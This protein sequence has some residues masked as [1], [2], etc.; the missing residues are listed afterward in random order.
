ML[1]PNEERRRSGSHYTPR[2]LTEP[3]VRTMLWRPSSNGYR[4][5][6]GRAPTPARADPR[7]SRSATRPWAPAAFLVETCRQLGDALVEAWHAHDALPTIPPDENEVIFARR[8]VAQRCLYGV[9]KNSMAVDL[10]KVSLWLVTLA[11]D[12]PLTFLAHALRHG[13]SLVGL[14]RGQI[15]AFHWNPGKPR[16]GEGFETMRVR[17]RTA[18]IARLRQLIR[19]ADDT[20]PDSELRQLWEQAQP[21]LDNVRLLGDLALA[22]F[23]T[24]SRPREREELRNQFADEVVNGTADHHRGR[25]EEWRSTERPLV[26]FHWQ[27]EFPEVFDRANPGFDAIIGNPPFAGKNTVAAGNTRGYPDW[28]KETHEGSHGNADLVAHFF[29]RAFS[30][31]RGGGTFGLIATNTIAQGDTRAT[32][33]RWSAPTAARS[34]RPTHAR[35]GPDKQRSSSAS[36]T[37]SK[38][39]TRAPKTRRYG[40]RDDHG[41]PVPP[42]QPRRP[43]PAH[44]ERRKK[45]PRQH[46]SR[47]GLH[48]RRHRHQRRRH[49]PRQDATS[50]PARPLQPEVILPYI[51]GKEINTSPTHA[52]HRYVI[53]FGERSEQECR[54]RWPE[55]MAIVEEKGKPERMKVNREVR[56]ERWWQF[57]DRQP[58]LY[59]AIAGL[60]RVLAISRVGQQAA[61]AFLPNGMV[62]A[63]RLIVFPL[64]THAA[65]CALQ[66]RPHEI[67]ARFFGS[68]M[69][70]DLLYT[71][72]DVFETFSFPKGWETHS[73]L[74]AA[75]RV[76]YDFRA[77]LM[78]RNDEGLTEIYNRFHDPNETDP[79]IQKLRELHAAIDRAVLDAYGWGDVPTGCGFLLDYEIGE[80]EGRS[81]RRRPYRYRWPD[82]VRDEVLARLL[83]LNAERAKEESRSGATAGPKQAR[84]AAAATGGGEPETMGLFS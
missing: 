41:V 68:S 71:P 48:V 17:E 45:L 65:F 42:G 72:S 13:D 33:L 76:Y 12:H 84:K 27:I 11:R 16:P 31:L 32:G 51:G 38:V 26:P 43:R 59:R 77:A 58:A 7:A 55:L 62:Y 74:E 46:R 21:E 57:G 34:T 80:E 61:I 47:H 15:E 75:G 63:D 44:R 20:V 82:D 22:A 78:V 19:D 28:L 18:E 67:W 1:Q 66:C 14:T 83:E 5:E 6:D 4:G 73:A 64:T 81:R 79:E 54:Q 35:N 60:E 30:L 2:E 24:G 8:L 69:K 56:R 52:H 25:L 37:S 53:N 10:A 70:D 50:D 36:R 9:D 3:I 29:R 49:T 23:F 39:G 40:R